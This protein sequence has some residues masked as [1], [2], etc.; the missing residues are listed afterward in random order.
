MKEPR[1]RRRP[2]VEIAAGKA[3]FADA[4]RHGDTKVA[5]SVYAETGRL[6]APSTEVIEGRAAIQ[7]FW[8]AGVD[9]GVV[10]VELEALDIQRRGDI[11]YEIGGYHLRLQP[12]VGGTVVDRGRYVLILEQDAD[13][14]WRRAVEMFS[15]DA[16][17]PSTVGASN[18]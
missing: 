3:T 5:A 6:L 9:A 2:D 10:E 4:L 11:A 14:S 1:D 16:P 7:A 18:G 8:Q 12:A 17:M 13:G 15:P